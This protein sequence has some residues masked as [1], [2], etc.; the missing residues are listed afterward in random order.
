MAISAILRRPFGNP[1]ISFVLS[2]AEGLRTG[3]RA[4][5]AVTVEDGGRKGYPGNPRRIKGGER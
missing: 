5:S 3:L 1:S 4:D 2:V